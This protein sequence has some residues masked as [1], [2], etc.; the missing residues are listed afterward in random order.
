MC[1]AHEQSW[2]HCAHAAGELQLL[3]N[4]SLA[5]SRGIHSWHGSGTFKCPLKGSKCRHKAPNTQ[6][7]KHESRR[8]ISNRSVIGVN[9]TH[10]HATGNST[11]ISLKICAAGIS[12][13][14]GQ[15]IPLHILCP[16][17]LRHKN[18]DKLQTIAPCWNTNLPSFLSHFSRRS[19][20][21][22]T[23]HTSPH[24]VADKNVPAIYKQLHSISELK[25]FPSSEYIHNQAI[26]RNRQSNVCQTIKTAFTDNRNTLYALAGSGEHIKCKT[27]WRR[28]GLLRYDNTWHLNHSSAFWDAILPFKC[29]SVPSL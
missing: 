29:L 27:F 8:N 16:S 21:S 6:K 2:S 26:I 28:P 5:S 22:Q 9:A 15:R 7:S 18:K 4:L 20:L 12:H 3:C 1:T 11:G 17:L 13:Q 23:A 25:L 14:W 24:Q 10:A 19:F